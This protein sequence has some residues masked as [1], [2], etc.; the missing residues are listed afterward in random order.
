MS[1]RLI[2]EPDEAADMVAPA[3][4]VLY[5]PGCSTPATMLAALGRAAERS[6]GRTL[7]GGLLLGDQ[8]WSDAVRDG[9]LGLRTWH[10]AGPAR[11]LVDDGL[12]DYVPLRLGD[13]AATLRRSVDAMVLR[14]SPPDADAMCSI[15][16][17]GSY[18]MAGVAA[19]RAGG[20]LVIG[21]IDPRLPRT[22]GPT[23]LPV[24][25][26]SALVDATEP[27]RTYQAAVVGA[28]H[29]RIAETIL[30]LLPARPTVQLGIGAVPEAVTAALGGLRRGSLRLV[31][32][33]ADGVAGL[34]DAGTLAA[35]VRAVEVLGSRRLLDYV[36]ANP[37][38]EVHPSATVHDPRWVARHA[39][40]VSVNSALEVDCSGQVALESAGGGP[41]P[42][43]AARSTSS[44]AP[45]SRTTA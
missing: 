21:E 19:V 2:L 16:P 29:R 12:A 26:L 22:G 35:P 9:H 42:G 39:R 44:R 43:W 7:V 28:A 31:G 5:S 38:V 41:W 45:T 40:F 11:R 6:P 15:G 3:A 36:D 30:D 33:A 23:V 24:D 27:T 14:V 32:M 25:H 13:V 37:M 17:S 20:G 34:I 8:P 18:T 1:I 4:R 10:A